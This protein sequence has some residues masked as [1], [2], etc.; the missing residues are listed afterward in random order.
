MS[1][2]R[3]PEIGPTNQALSEGIVRAVEPQLA[4]ILIRQQVRGDRV[5]ATWF[6]LGAR[7][8]A[9]EEELDEESEKSK[10]L[11][12]IAEGLAGIP[13]RVLGEVAGLLWLEFLRVKT[14]RLEEVQDVVKYCLAVARNRI[15]RYYGQ[16]R[17]IT[18][19]FFPMVE[20]LAER[21]SPTRRSRWFLLESREELGR[22]YRRVEKLS[23]NERE[24]LCYR[25]ELGLTFS[26]I[27]TLIGVPR[28]TCAHR[29][30]QALRRLA[31]LQPSFGLAGG[32]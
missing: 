3:L 15:R 29:Y 31:S 7:V 12:E 21:R 17:R 19:R 26:D 10:K 6:E 5:E 30:G 14:A 22:I 13:N 27:A 18:A 28:S 23:F 20:E 1:G 2:H 16:E 4:T 11:K 9:L 24:V 8:A 25:L 32:S